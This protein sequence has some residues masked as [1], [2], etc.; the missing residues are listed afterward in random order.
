M[1][2]ISY[3]I[4]PNPLN[5]RGGIT[6]HLG[7]QEKSSMCKVATFANPV[8]AKM[9]ADEFEFPLSDRVISIIEK[10]G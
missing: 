9:F 1:S 2:K 8:V 5:K 3:S 6:L 7:R 4:E 10:E